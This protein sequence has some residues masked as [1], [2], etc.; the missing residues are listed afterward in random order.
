MQKYF[1]KGAYSVDEANPK[2]EEL[3]GRDFTEPVGADQID[4]TLLPE[5]MQVR[6]EDYQKKG[7]TKWT[8]LRAEDTTTEEYRKEIRRFEP[9]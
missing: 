1:H 7:R 9:S 8:N 6:G 3:R 2:A 5:R 4:E